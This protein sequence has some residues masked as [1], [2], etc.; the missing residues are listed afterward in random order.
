M[1]KKLNIEL[2]RF[3]AKSDYLPYYKK[4]ILDI[5]N[6][7]LLLELLHDLYAIEKFKFEDNINYTIK[8]ND[9]YFSMSV[10]IEEVCIKLDTNEWRIEP[11]STF[12]AIEDLTIDTSDFTEKVNLL[13]NYIDEKEKEQYM[14]E[15]LVDYY[16]SSSY[17]LHR[18]YIGD[19]VVLIIDKLLKKSNENED[20]LLSLLSNKDNGIYYHTSVVEK[21]YNYNIEKEKNILA[22][23]IKVPLTLQKDF[24][25]VDTS[26]LQ[27]V[28]Q[29]FERFNIASFDGVNKQ[30]FQKTIEKT[31]ATFIELK[32]SK[33]DL[34]VHSFSVSKDFSLRIV[35]NILLEAV[36]K[37]A[38]FLIVR[39]SEDLALFDAQQSKAEKLIGR[40]FLLPIITREEFIKIA[41]GHLEDIKSK[42]ETHKVK[43]S[44]I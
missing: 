23:M 2:F 19:S 34:A 18:E 20:E 26:E 39:G 21:I 22:L 35:A 1:L 24:Y 11:I 25:I 3:D 36:D 12:R 10:T 17:E 7:K 33:E 30:S 32:N 16:A 31:K 6:D 40:E 28:K 37:N 38:D 43:V 8:I 44:F 29:S 15:Y 42:L 9:I 41:E 4:N 13:S 5:Q 27:D 14:E